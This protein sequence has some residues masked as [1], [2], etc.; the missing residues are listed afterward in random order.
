MI[1]VVSLS[2]STGG[3]FT[4]AIF[5]NNQV[6]TQTKGFNGYDPMCPGLPRKGTLPFDIV[7]YSLFVHTFCVEIKIAPGR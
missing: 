1:A 7:L 3:K 4:H 5:E 6:F 2:L